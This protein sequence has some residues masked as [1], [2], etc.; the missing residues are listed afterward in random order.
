MYSWP[1][2]FRDFLTTNLL[3]YFSK[4]CQKMIVVEKGLFLP[5]KYLWSK[6]KGLQLTRENCTRECQQFA[7]T[8][9]SNR[10]EKDITVV[11]LACAKIRAHGNTN[12]HNDIKIT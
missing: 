5:T 12:I 6:M 3:I 8:L 9:F 10:F 4:I 7:Q 1:S 2:L 11:T